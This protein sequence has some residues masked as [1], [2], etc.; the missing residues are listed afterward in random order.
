M[1]RLLP[2]DKWLILTPGKLA[3]D[4][5][6]KRKVSDKNRTKIELP[7]LDKLVFYTW[8]AIPDTYMNMK[9]YAFGVLSIFGSTHLCKQVFS[10]VNYIKSK[11]CSRLTDESL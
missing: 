6:Q 9:K 2:P 3:M 1:Q 8:N 7:K 4:K 5:S 11:H 10:I